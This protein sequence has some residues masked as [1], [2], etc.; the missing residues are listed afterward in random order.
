MV[1]RTLKKSRRAA[2]ASKRKTR[3]RLLGS[4]AGAGS[5]LNRPMSK[6]QSF[7]GIYLVTPLLSEAGPFLPALREALAA[8]NVA[9]VLLRPAEI[10]P[11]ALRRLIGDIAPPVA[12]AGAA[13]MVACDP[14]TAQEAG[15]DGVHVSGAEEPLAAAIKLL[16]PERM[17]GA[18]GL[19]TR[20]DAMKA[21]EDGADYVLFGDWDAPLEGEALIERVQWWAEVF[22]IPCVAMAASLA[23]V[24]PLA[25]AGADFLMLGDCV[26]NDPRGPREAVR[27]A[28]RATGDIPA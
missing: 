8:G 16:A 14:K 7:P 6:A 4:F 5:R 24:G 12:E 18:G 11:G 3:S 26:W 25:E 23:E 10:D 15:A 21:G 22:N 20:H 2:L 28:R 17:V 27:D 1:A 19:A 13:L 9:S